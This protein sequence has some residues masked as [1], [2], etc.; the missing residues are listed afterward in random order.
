MAL[1]ITSNGNFVS[2]GTGTSI[3]DLPAAGFSGWI[4]L[5][6]TSNAASQ[7][8]FSKRNS[9]G[10]GLVIEV[11]GEIRFIHLRATANTDFT[12]DVGASNVVGLN[13]WTFVGFTFDDTA[14][15]KVKLY[16]G[17]LT[18]TVAEISYGA[19]TAGTGALTSD[20]TAN[21][22]VGNLHQSTNFPFKGKI[23]R[24]GLVNRVLTLA[25]FKRLQF[26]SLAQCNVSGTKL[27]FH[28]HGTGTQP[29]LSGNKNNGSVTGATVATG[30]PMRP[31][32]GNIATRGG[33]VGGGSV[34]SAPFFVTEQRV[35]REAVRR[36]IW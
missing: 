9:N 23:D 24:G 3:D 29:D 32:F 34:A 27:L 19:T 20:A 31:S 11:N 6:G 35:S 17:T 15:P 28:L 14:T 2:F 5:Y 22:Y 4:W 30:M 8:P 21:L 10:W 36:S 25:E 12:G 7:T 26:A 18:G 13:A 16:R 33:I 1:D